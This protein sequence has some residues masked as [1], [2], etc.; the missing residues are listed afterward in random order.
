MAAY[1]RQAVARASGAG[2][3]TVAGNWAPLT[4]SATFPTMASGAGGTVTFFGVGTL[5]SGTWQLIFFGAVS[6][7]ISVVNGVTPKLDTT[8]AV[9]NAVDALANAAAT[10]FLNLLF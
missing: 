4:T 5:T 7:T 3:W 1:A 6:P 2:G 9:T 8:T 10:A